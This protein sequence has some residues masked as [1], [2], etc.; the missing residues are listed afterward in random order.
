VFIILSQEFIF[1]RN[2]TYQ[3]KFHCLLDTNGITL[4]KE[5]ILKYKYAT[6]KKCNNSNDARQK[7]AAMELKTLRLNVWQICQ[8]ESTET[9]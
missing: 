1:V 2:K 4:A 3:N 7:L 9:P 6:Y 8:L 5:K